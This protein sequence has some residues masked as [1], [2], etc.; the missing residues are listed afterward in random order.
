MPPES[1]GVRPEDAVR[2]ILHQ[3]PNLPDS[4]EL[5]AH[6]FSL[7][8]ASLELRR[9]ALLLPDYDE[10]VFVPW[11][12][13]GLDAT[14]LHRLRI[15]ASDLLAAAKRSDAGLFWIGEQ[16]RD[17]APYFSRREATMLEHLLLVPLI[18]RS[19]LQAVLL[20]T[21]TPYFATHTEYLR[22]ILAAVGEPAARIIQEQR[23]AFF[24]QIRQSILFKTS[25]IGVVSARVVERSPTGL[26]LVLVELSDIVS[27]VASSNEHLDPYRVWQDVLR[28]VT[29]LF[30]S[31]ASVCEADDHR[32]LLLLH[33]QIDDDIEL[34]THHIAASLRRLF[35]EIATASVL[36]YVS[37]RF[38]DD[39]DD[40]NALIST[41][42]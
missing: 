17:F 16:S 38:P 28:V 6:L 14:S 25:E 35:P 4:I 26:R 30:A 9:S 15:P 8:V 41:L 39:G 12:S 5:P 10:D 34:L 3:L 20:V 1:P 29:A 31:T 40:L 23:I 21:D 36:Q 22:I 37:R 2:S 19:E 13:N 24:Q 18:Y 42:L 32:A 27:Q 33:G 7:L 11:A